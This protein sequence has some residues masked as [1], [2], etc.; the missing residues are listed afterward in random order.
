MSKIAIA[1]GTLVVIIIVAVLVAGGVSAGIS[2]MSVGPAGP[3]GDIGATG[4][5]GAAGAQGPK[6]DTGATGATGP[7]GT[8]ATGPA[9]STGA[10][11]AAGVAG[12]KGDTGATG[13]TGAKGDTG[14]QGIQGLKGD[15]GATGAT[16]PQG[17][18]GV[19]VV[20]STFV[21]GPTYLPS[22]TAPKSIGNVTITAP[23]NGKVQVTLSGWAWMHDND[24]CIL[25]IG[26]TP[27]DYH[28]RFTVEGGST[29]NTG[30]QVLWSSLTVQL[31]YDMT[32][33]SKQTFYAT[34]VKNFGGSLP[35]YIR[36]VTMT[37]IFYAT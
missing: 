32:A 35:M 13:A 5:T 6:G 18:A 31:I 14:A 17:P 11:G 28:G 24:S 34:P 19:T 2:V 29:G 25:G 26:L 4:A 9:G 8:G 16:G 36:D 3:K 1:K 7:A 15:T 33:G 21:V 12:A 30:N 10:T 20:N 27:D 37:A 23:V 22:W